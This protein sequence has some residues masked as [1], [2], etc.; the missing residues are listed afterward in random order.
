MYTC[1]TFL[2]VV[3]AE[4]SPPWRI[5]G[6]AP[7]LSRLPLLRY[8][9]GLARQTCVPRFC[10]RRRADFS[11]LPPKIGLPCALVVVPR[12]RRRQ[13]PHRRTPLG[14]DGF[15]C[16]AAGCAAVSM[17]KL[18]QPYSG[19]GAHDWHHCLAHDGLF[20]M[21]ARGPAS[22]P[23]QKSYVERVKKRSAARL[24]LVPPGVGKSFG[25][26][27]SRLQRSPCAAVC[28]F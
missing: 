1:T 28:L 9:A 13:A 6:D 26:R 21:L 18:A 24:C 25:A 12:P 23:S 3:K 19:V 27:E 22:I 17:L 7:S 15:D 11:E 4:P 14:R 5:A 2:R 8:G 10:L 20:L 16:P